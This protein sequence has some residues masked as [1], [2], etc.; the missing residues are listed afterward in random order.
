VIACVGSGL[1]TFAIPPDQHIV[2]IGQPFSATGFAREHICWVWTNIVAYVVRSFCCWTAIY[3]FDS[4]NCTLK[5]AGPAEDRAARKKNTIVA[6]IRLSVPN[7]ETSTC[8][9]LPVKRRRVDCP[10]YGL[11]GWLH[12]LFLNGSPYGMNS[13]GFLGALPDRQRATALGIVHN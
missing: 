7:R 5:A 11:N 4:C 12:G 13:Y 2:R 3:I 9:P 1:H 6:P 8:L 10:C